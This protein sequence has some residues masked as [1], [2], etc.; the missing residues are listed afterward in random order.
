MVE[1][2]LV[3]KIM[4]WAIPILFAITVHE[5][6]HG[7]VAY[8]LGDPTAKM[9]GRVTLN[10]I[11]HI[12]ILGTIV[13]PL[14]LLVLSGG[15]FVFGW[16]KPVPVTWDNLKKP[17][18]DMALVAIA[19]PASNIIMALLW[20]VLVK[21][22]VSVES[23]DPFVAQSLAYMGVAGIMI[24]LVLCVLNLIPLPPLDGSRVV[25]SFL[26][27]KA[28]LWYNGIERY[29][30]IILLVLMVSGLLGKVMMPIVSG[31]YVHILRLFG[32]I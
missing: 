22:G 3:Q 32:V 15:M 12:D 16:A 29:G 2:N 1:F 14:A 13:V 31:L 11:K 21:V 25:T 4:L 24:N 9:L 8:K 6:A 7:Y 27:R 18:R 17:R 19:G 10:P 30:F 5:V 20:A 28:A 26:S 23:L